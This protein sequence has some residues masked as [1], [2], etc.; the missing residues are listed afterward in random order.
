MISSGF[1]MQHKSKKGLSTTL[2]FAPIFI[3]Q[4]ARCCQFENALLSRWK[5]PKISV[6]FSLLVIVFLQC[7]P[8]CLLYCWFLLRA[9]AEIL[10]FLSPTHSRCRIRV[11]FLNPD[12]LWYQK[13]KKKK[14]FEKE[15]TLFCLWCGAAECCFS[16]GTGGVLAFQLCWEAQ[17]LH[18]AEVGARWKLWS[19][20]IV[21][22]VGPWCS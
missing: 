11:G 1:R 6:A 2:L 9:E 19:C 8:S 3:W 7:L 4:A 20:L 15:W 14:S 22:W 10:N 17:T 12:L 5:Q 16:A 18:R 13:K 21:L